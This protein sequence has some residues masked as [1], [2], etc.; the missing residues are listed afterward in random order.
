MSDNSIFQMEKKGNIG[1]VTFNVVRT[2]N[3]H[4]DREGHSRLSGPGRR[5]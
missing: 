5:A 3:E 2:A 4:L 1:I